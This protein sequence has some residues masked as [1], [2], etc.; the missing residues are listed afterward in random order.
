[1]SLASASP[2]AVYRDGRRTKR[3]IV[4]GLF[5]VALLILAGTAVWLV[6][7][8]SRPRQPGAV[9]ISIEIPKGSS[10]EEIGSLLVKQKIISSATDF[11]VAVLLTGARG[12][13]QAGTYKL[14]AG[15]SPREIVQHLR[16]G[17]A[18][19]SVTIPE[20]LRLA[21]IADRI[22]KA[23]V[24]SHAD[25]IAATRDKFDFDFLAAVPANATLEGYLFPDTYNFSDSVSPHDVVKRMLQ[26]FQDK[27]GPL[28]PEITAGKHSLHEIL[29]I[30]SIVEAEVAKSADRPAVASVFYNRLAAGMALQSDTTVAFALNVRKVDLSAADLATD[31]PYNTR[32]NKGLPPGPIDSPGLDAIQ[33]AL[34]P[35]QTDYL[36]FVSKASTGDTLFAKT[37]E[38]HNKNVAKTK[39]Q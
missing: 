32:V 34:H 22:D 17:T 30:A 3:R 36:Y 37:L 4:L 12:K 24:V 35:A 2:I 13:L 18:Q 7:G 25:F 5:A 11:T 26:N 6:S 20:G 19:A 1:M 38:E 31:S 28:L 39:G 27:I 10:T 8:A 15:M 21:E 33:A 14:S 16:D 9:A 29:T 23:G